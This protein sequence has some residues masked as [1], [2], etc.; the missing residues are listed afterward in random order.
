V[1]FTSVYYF[2]SVLMVQRLLVRVGKSSTSLHRLGLMLGLLVYVGLQVS[3]RN[4]TDLSLGD[5]PAELVGG[6]VLLTVVNSSFPTT[7]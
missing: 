7:G 3:A 1:F 6:C 4:G 5:V 2:S